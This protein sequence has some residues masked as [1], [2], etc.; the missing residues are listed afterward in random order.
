MHLVLEIYETWIDNIDLDADN[1]SE[2]SARSF[3]NK[4][5]EIEQR[6]RERLFGY[7]SIVINNTDGTMKYGIFDLNIFKPPIN[8]FRKSSKDLISDKSVKITLQMPEH[9]DFEE[10]EE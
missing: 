7:S 10:M 3:L 6:S 1:A 2:N 5:N 8:L 4:F 9:K